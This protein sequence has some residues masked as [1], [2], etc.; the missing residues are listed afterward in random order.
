MTD[1]QGR[2]IKGYEL[3]NRL[4]VGGFGAVYRAYQPLVGREVAIKIILPEHADQ[5]DFV[6]RFESEARL[7]AR[8]EHPH[9]VPMFDYWREPGGAYL[10]MRYLRGGSL[11]DALDNKGPF[12]SDSA[13][14]LVEQITAAL[15][16]AHR[17]NIVHRDIKPDNIML[18]EYGNAYL[19]DFG[20]ATISADMRGP[21]PVVAA[22][23]GLSGSFTYM[24]PEQIKSEPITTRTDIYSMG[25]VIFEMMTGQNPYP[26]ATL[27]E[28]AFKHL[29]D[30]LPDVRE[31][32]PELPTALND[33]IQQATAKDPLQRYPDMLALAADFRQ[34]FASQSEVGGADMLV[35][36]F[37]SMNAESVVNPYKGL[38][39]FEEA[40]AADFFGREILIE[41]LIGRLAE[42]DPQAHFLAVVGPSGS[43]KSS[44]VKAGV[45]PAL[46][47]G[48]LPGSEHWYTAEIVPGSHP[49]EKLVGAL[50]SVAVTPPGDVLARL[51]AD[52]GVLLTLI[53]EILPPDAHLLLVIDQFEEVLPW[54]K[55]RTNAPNFWTCCAR[56]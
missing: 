19:T 1:Y 13:L 11:R 7:V 20:L 37:S 14:R 48:E 42:P 45:L 51:Q 25:I 39:P 52:P 23:E 9:I 4:G 34:A 26:G 40:D 3:R 38:R 10:V 55:P 28:M 12:D 33:L 5:P 50:V 53:N 6:R 56:L 29:H 44:V 35:F 18:D 22:D 8:L 43:G 17:N 47:R 49:L 2:I 36:D 54:S 27:S 24:S 30:P 46:H 32:R 15:A 41:Q 31:L 21:K 16:V